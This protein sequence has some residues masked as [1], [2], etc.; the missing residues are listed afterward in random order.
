MVWRTGHSCGRVAVPERRRS[1]LVLTGPGPCSRTGSANRAEPSH[2]PVPHL[3]AFLQGTHW[4][5]IN[6][7]EY[8]ADLVLLIVL[9][10]LRYKLSLHDLARMFLER[11]FVFTHESARV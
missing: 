6:F 10:C 2:L 11:G 8:P 7:L 1:W 9:C 3:L 5:P 4:D